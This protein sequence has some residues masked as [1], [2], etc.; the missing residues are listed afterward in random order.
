MQYDR[1]SQ[2]QLSFLL[3]IHLQ[4]TCVRIAVPRTGLWYLTLAPAMEEEIGE[5]VA[6]TVAEEV[7]QEAAAAGAIGAAP[8][9]TLACALHFFYSTLFGAV[10][11]LRRSVINLGGPGQLSPSFNPPFFPSLSLTP[12]EVWAELA[13]P[14]PVPNISM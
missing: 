10:Q 13:H 1:L 7:S 3:L 9:S 5:T 6:E 4:H 11:Q 12:Q 2:Q 8:N 14:L